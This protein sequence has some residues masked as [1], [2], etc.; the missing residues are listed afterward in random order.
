MSAS[1]F[2]WRALSREWA[3]VLACP[4]WRR[5]TVVELILE[6][7]AAGEI[8]EQLLEAHPR[9]TREAIQAANKRIQL[10][11]SRSLLLRGAVTA[12][13]VP[14]RFLKRPGGVS[15]RKGPKA[16]SYSYPIEIPAAAT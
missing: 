15:I 2:W 10:R 6:K 8:L 7:L 14:S 9:L 11:A 16:I 12:R 4:P 5:A 3:A 1:A 13:Q